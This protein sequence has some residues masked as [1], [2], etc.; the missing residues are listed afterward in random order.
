MSSLWLTLTLGYLKFAKCL[1]SFNRR[2]VKHIF[3]RYI[4]RCCEW[5]LHDLHWSLWRFDKTAL[6]VFRNASTLFKILSKQRLQIF[7]RWNWAYIELPF[8]QSTKI[9]FMQKNT[10]WRLPGHF[11]NPCLTDW[12]WLMSCTALSLVRAI[13][14]ATDSQTLVVWY[15]WQH[16]VMKRGH[17]MLRQLMMTLRCII[18]E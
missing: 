6:F 12:K 15:V 4:L 14:G 17:L 10:W 5:Q 1:F 2:K 7:Y 13:K 18:N 11:C 16:E 8:I 3:Y 9:V